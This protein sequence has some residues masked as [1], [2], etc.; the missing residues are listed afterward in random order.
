MTTPSIGLPYIHDKGGIYYP[1]FIAQNKDTDGLSV[2]HLKLLIPIEENPDAPCR[3][4]RGHH[5]DNI[6]YK[7]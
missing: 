2:D 6:E 3:T 1:L 4:S 7:K 5:F